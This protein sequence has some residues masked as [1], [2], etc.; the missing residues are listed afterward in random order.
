MQSAYK[1]FHFTETA[2]L[3][4]QNEIYA[5][6]E[7]GKVTSMTLLDLSAAFDT[8]DHDILLNRLREWFGLNDLALGWIASYL[9]NRTQ[10]D[11]ISQLHQPL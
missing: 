2:L 8:I 4:I 6:M 10:T 7:K 9:R 3:T 1:A 5:A 11:K